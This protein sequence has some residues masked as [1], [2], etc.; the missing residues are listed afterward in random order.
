MPGA[1]WPAATVFVFVDASP[2]E[3]AAVFADYG[4][5]QAFIPDIKYSRVARVIDRSTV[6]VDYVIALPVIS[7]EK[8]TV[9]NHIVIDSAGRYRVDWSLV[10]A[11]S[12][13][14]IVGHAVFSRYV[15]GRTRRAGTLLEYY[16]FVTP[17]SRIAGAS[18]IRNRAIAQ[19]AE[20]ARAIAAEIDRTRRQP[21]TLKRRI[22][23]LR[24]SV[25]PSPPKD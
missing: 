23:A 21:A 4:A 20:A 10:R 22:A 2:E 8:Y 14:G 3:A 12:M 7:D 9:R 1:P 19:I 13:K 18:F 11:S 6:E 5:H 15:N 24:A 16:D 17:G 25:E